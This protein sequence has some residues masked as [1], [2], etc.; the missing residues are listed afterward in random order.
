MKT[1]YSV[2]FELIGGVEFNP[3]R[4]IALSD[5]SSIY[6]YQGGSPDVRGFSHSLVAVYTKKTSN[7]NTIEKHKNNL[8]T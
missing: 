6:V 5:I 4:H 8:F 2:Q 3:L 7:Y 1:S